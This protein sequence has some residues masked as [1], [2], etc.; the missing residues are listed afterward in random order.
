MLFIHCY[1]ITV[2]VKN[3]FSP[4][5]LTSKSEASFLHELA[6]HEQFFLKVHSHWTVFG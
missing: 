2:V 1:Q 5:S 4:S 3:K 6:F